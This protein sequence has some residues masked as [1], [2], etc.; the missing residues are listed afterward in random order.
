MLHLNENMEKEKIESSDTRSM[1]CSE[2]NE[3]NCLIECK[4]PKLQDGSQSEASVT[5]CECTK[6]VKKLRH[7]I[8]T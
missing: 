1:Q 2:N 8:D 4:H 6:D 5:Q 3:V 7:A